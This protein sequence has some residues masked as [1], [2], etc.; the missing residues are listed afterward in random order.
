[1]TNP[2][3]SYVQTDASGRATAFVGPDAVNLYRAATLVSGLRLYAKTKIKLTRNATPAVMLSMA[4]QYTGKAYK[5]GQY[6]QAAADVDSWVQTMKAALPYER[7]KVKRSRLS[8][9]SMV[10][11]G[12]KKHPVVIDGGIVKEWVGIGW[13]DLHPAGASDY[14]HFPEVED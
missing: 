2:N 6:L 7:Q 11:G 3:Q 8:N 1:M 9:I 10:E 14:E 13:I 12:E 5:R 4:T